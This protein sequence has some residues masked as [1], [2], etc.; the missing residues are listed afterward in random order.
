MWCTGLRPAF[1]MHCFRNRCPQGTLHA[2]THRAHFMPCIAGICSSIYMCALHITLIH[3]CSQALFIHIHVRPAH[4]IDSSLFGLAVRVGLSRAFACGSCDAWEHMKQNNDCSQHI[5]RQSRNQMHEFTIPPP[6]RSKARPA[7]DVCGPVLLCNHA[8]Q[9][10]NQTV[11][12]P[13]H[14]DRAGT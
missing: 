8:N 7:A 10:I 11:G 14:S 2:R 9:S 3:H 6:A 13:L 4:Q 5:I 1:F 12:P